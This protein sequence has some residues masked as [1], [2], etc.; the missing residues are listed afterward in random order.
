MSEQ[1]VVADAAYLTAADEGNVVL[2]IGSL[3]Y[4]ADDK[5]P[6]TLQ[7]RHQ[8]EGGDTAAHFVT[9]V[10]H[11]RFGDDEDNWPALALRFTRF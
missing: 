1:I 3:A 9:Q 2:C 8:I 6:S 5:I 11:R 4:A 10:M 7:A